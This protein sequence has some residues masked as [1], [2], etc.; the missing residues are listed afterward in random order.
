MPPPYKID[1]TQ[2]IRQF[3]LNYKHVF[4]LEFL[5]KGIHEW[6]LEEDYNGV[7]QSGE[8]HDNWIE[9]LYLERMLGPGVK[10]IWIWWRCQKDFSPLVKFHLNIDY[11]LLGLTDHEV[12]VDGTK[13][14]TNKGEVEVFVTAKMQLDG[15]EWNKHFFLKNKLL[16]RFYL[17]R[18]YKRQLEY[19]EAELVKDAA[20]LLGMVKQYLQMDSWLPEY[21]RKPFQPVKGEID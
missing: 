18:L 11:H 15:A 16:Q 20:R 13:I 21:A 14:K 12:V 4:S 3:S 10:Q 17:N 5:Y 2:V 7:S 6:L 1:E 8:H 19:A 9:K